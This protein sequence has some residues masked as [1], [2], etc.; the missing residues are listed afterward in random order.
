M[1]S[2]GSTSCLDKA[3]DLYAQALASH[4]N[5]EAIRTNIA[6]VRKRRD[7]AQTVKPGDRKAAL[8]QGVRHK[9]QEIP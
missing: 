8:D 9:D 3:L 1:R 5:P 4:P 6:A 2:C 7:A